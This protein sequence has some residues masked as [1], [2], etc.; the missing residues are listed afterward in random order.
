MAGTTGLEPAASAVTGQRS[1]Q[2]N[3]VPTHERDA[4]SPGLCDVARFLYCPICPALLRCFLPIRTRKSAARIRTWADRRH[5]NIVTASSRTRKT[6]ALLLLNT[7]LWLAIR[8]PA[9]VSLSYRGNQRSRI[10]IFL[11]K[12]G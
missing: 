11:Q 1:N 10:R 12:L 5:S 6:S 7:A 2:L 9:R 8:N 3:Y 4:Q